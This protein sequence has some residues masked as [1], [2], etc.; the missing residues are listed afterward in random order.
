MRMLK[1]NTMFAN[2]F[3]TRGD[4]ENQFQFNGVLKEGTAGK[5]NIAAGNA[6]TVQQR[7]GLLCI[8]ANVEPHGDTTLRTGNI[9]RTNPANGRILNSNRK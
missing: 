9:P 4:R 7:E 1:E 6:L 8:I 2:Q 3:S 5:P